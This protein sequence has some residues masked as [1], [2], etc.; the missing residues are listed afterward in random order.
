MKTSILI[1]GSLAL[2]LLGTGCA[3]K[4]YVAK[5]IAPVEQRVSTAEAKNTEQDTKLAANAS[6]IDAVDKDLSRTKER[7]TDT[8]AKAV[9]AGNAAAAANAAA[10]SAASAA[11][12]ADAKGQQGIQ[13]GT[14]AAKS[15]DTLRED[16]RN[17]KFKMT[18][19][20]TVLFGFNRKTLS[21][22]A[23]AQLDSFVQSLDGINRYVVEI[24]GFTDKTGSAVYNDELSQERAEAVA[25]YL[26]SHKVPLRSITMLGT[27][28]AE[29]DQKTREER[30]QGR[31]VDVRI[32]I[33]EI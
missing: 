20:D 6:Q 31:K 4:K 7:L 23:K 19:S 12:A 16:V 27:G 8:D 21:D 10:A 2:S 33:P 15:V 26:A 3:T 29:G 14:T 24:Q 11:S 9:A 1:A 32:Y 30:A 22:E 17:G 25:R 28:V 5:S 13:V 18:K